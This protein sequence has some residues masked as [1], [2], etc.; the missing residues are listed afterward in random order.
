MQR[1]PGRLVGT[2]GVTLNTSRPLKMSLLDP[3][4]HPA[5]LVSSDLEGRCSQGFP[6]KQ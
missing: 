3:D 1:L 5:N 6:A 2:Q 4:T